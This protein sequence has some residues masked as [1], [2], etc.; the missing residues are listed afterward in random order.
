MPAKAD[1][2]SKAIKVFE[3]SAMKQVWSSLGSHALSSLGIWRSAPRDGFYSVGDVLVSSAYQFTSS[4][5]PPHTY[6]LQ[7]LDDKEAFRPPDSYEEVWTSSG[8]KSAEYL[9]L[10]QLNCPEIR[11]LNRKL[12]IF[13]TARHT[14]RVKIID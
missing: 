13:M 9:T 3:V 11:M 14:A 4:Q 2:N 1:Y 10:F 12:A 7:A 5:A 8:M 6:L